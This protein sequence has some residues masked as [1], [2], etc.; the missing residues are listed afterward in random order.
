MWDKTCSKKE[1]AFNWLLWNKAIVVNSQKAI[2]IV[3][4]NDKCPVCCVDCMETITHRSWDCRSAHVTWDFSIGFVNVM[5]AKLTQEGP[6]RP[7]DSN[8]RSLAQESPP[9]LVNSLEFGCSYKVSCYKPFGLKRTTLHSAILY[10][11]LKK[12]RQMTQQGILDYTKITW[13]IARKEVDKASN[14]DDMLGKFDQIWEGNEN[15]YH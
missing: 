8:M 7:L 5:K 13:D 15:L 1:G 12:M 4:V 10:G 11:I 2:F 9:L 14:Y 6:W 3:D